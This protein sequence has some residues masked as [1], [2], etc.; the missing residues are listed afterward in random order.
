MNY[1]LLHDLTED[2]VDAIIITEYP[3]EVIE[4]SIAKAKES[5]DY[6]WETLIENMPVGTSVVSC[7]N[8]DNRIYY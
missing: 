3:K 6:T 2:K 7:F 4:N 1:F 8:Q 5:E